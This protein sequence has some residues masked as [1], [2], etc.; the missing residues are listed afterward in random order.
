MIGKTMTNYQTA[1]ERLN[2]ANTVN[3]LFSLEKSF[4]TLYGCGVLNRS[5]F[6]KLDDML[7]DKIANLKEKNTD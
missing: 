6:L 1:V 7:C 4:V 5:N 2:K 3:D